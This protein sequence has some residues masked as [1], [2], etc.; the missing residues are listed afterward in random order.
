MDDG[1][2]GTGEAARSVEALGVARQ[3]LARTETDIRRS[4]AEERYTLFLRTVYFPMMEFGYLLPVV[5][6]LLIGGWYYVQGWADLRQ[7]T[8]ATLYVQQL[9]DPV[10]RLLAWLDQLQVGQGARARVL[11]VCHPPHDPTE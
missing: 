6:T 8:A 2:T 1:I 7:V 9:I 5:A 10:D 3:R 11:W 4:Y